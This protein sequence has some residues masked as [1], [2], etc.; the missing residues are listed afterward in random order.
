MSDTESRFEERRLA[1]HACFEHGRALVD[2]VGDWWGCCVLPRSWRQLSCS[3]PAHQL[4]ALGLV[5]NCVVLW[6][7]RYQDAAL[8]QLRAAGYPVADD[9]VARLSPFVRRHLNVHGKYSF[10]LPE[11]AGGLRTLRDPG[12]PDDE[13]D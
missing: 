12:A 4:G 11:L 7:T 2:D 13:E 3:A 5:L 10:S 6:T 9:D 8:A 1:G